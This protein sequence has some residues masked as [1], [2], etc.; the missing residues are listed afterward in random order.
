MLTVAEVLREAREIDSSFTP[1]RHPEGVVLRALA[2]IQ[3][4]L[5][6]ML[7]KVDERAVTSTLTIT[8]PLATFADGAP[9]QDDSTPPV[10]L[11][12]LRIH[13]PLDMYLSGDTR[14]R[15]L[16]LIDWA[17]RHRV[18]FVWGAWIRNNTLFLTGDENLWTDVTQIVVTYTATPGTVLIGGDLVLPDRAANAT[19]LMIADFMAGR[20]RPA[21]LSQ[22]RAQYRQDAVDAVGSW[23][24]SERRRIGVMVT[25][26]R[27]VTQ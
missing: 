19:V 16:D 20:A 21:E 26:V 15:R 24:D 25:Q 22:P 13:E 23:I 1:T 3:R 12:I 6:E 27:D 7:L 2:R 5:L 18:P 8:L 4:T 17:D 10:A 9:F 11:D 14:A